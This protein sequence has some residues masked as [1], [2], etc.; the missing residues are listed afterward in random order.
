MIIISIYYY[1][2]NI[3]QGQFPIKNTA[4]DGYVSTA[5][6]DAFEQNN[7]RLCNIIGNV[8][9]WIADWWETKHKVKV[10]RNPVST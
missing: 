6:I 5:P 9:E 7:Y 3:W 1:R 4:V 8:W 2:A 10:L